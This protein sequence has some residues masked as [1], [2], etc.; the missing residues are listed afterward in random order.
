[1]PSSVVKVCKQTEYSYIHKINLFLKRVPWS[2]TCKLRVR[3]VGAAAE[4]PSS[5]VTWQLEGMKMGVSIV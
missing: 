2:A 4:L 3:K 5:V 1:M